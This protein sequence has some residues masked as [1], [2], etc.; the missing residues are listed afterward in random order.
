MEVTVKSMRGMM[1]L[2]GNVA[3]DEQSKK[4]EE[5]IKS[6]RGVKEVR[7]RIRV[8]KVDD[9]SATKDADLMAKIEKEIENDEELTQARRK[10]DISIKDRNMTLKGE[11]Q[12][13]LAGGLAGQHGEARALLQLVE[14]RRAR[15]PARAPKRLR[16]DFT[17]DPSMHRSLGIAL[18]LGFARPR[19]LDAQRLGPEPGGVQ[20]RAQGHAELCTRSRDSW[21]SPCKS[22]RGM[23]MLTGNTATD[24]QSKKAEEIIKN[25]RGV[26]EV[27]NRIRV[28]KVDD[29][30]TAKDADLMAKIDKEIENDEELTQARRKLDISDQGPEH[31][32]FKGSLKDYSQAGSL[33][34]M[35][36]R[37]PCFNS[38]NFDELE[39]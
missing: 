21:R 27:R 9:C 10:F 22:M 32:A 4:A 2:T 20:A 14:L 15:V 30:S 25:M 39:Y 1:M 38:L 35:V 18:A 34:T 24:D 3:T 37:V 17:E 23:M 31:R 11:P 28:G 5:I 13:L 29:C 7:N 33:V 16:A 26:K 36:K 8:G 6:M 12:G 19:R